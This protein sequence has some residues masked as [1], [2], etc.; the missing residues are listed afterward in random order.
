MKKSGDVGEKDSDV[1]EYNY[2]RL[3]SYVREL[4]GI[5]TNI[6]LVYLQSFKKKL[7]IL[8]RI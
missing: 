7:E 2:G 8:I 6:H 4:I 1:D 3:V 5:A